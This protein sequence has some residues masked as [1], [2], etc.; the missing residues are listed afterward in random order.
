MEYYILDLLD[1]KINMFEL[2]VGEVDAILGDLE[3]KQEFSEQVMKAWVR[4]ESKEEVSAGLE[5][6]GEEMLKNKQ[7]LVAERNGRHT[8]LIFLIGRVSHLTI[9]AVR[10][11]G[12]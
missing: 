10:H 9:T 5:Q 6:I 3:E 12:D 11:R 8:V 7:K 1:R 2:V 4:A